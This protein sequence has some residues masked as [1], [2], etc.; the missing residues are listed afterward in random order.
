MILS[1]MAAGKYSDKLTSG[2]K[3][4]VNT[5]PRYI[6]RDTSLFIQCR[7]CGGFGYVQADGYP[8]LKPCSNCNGT[9]SKQIR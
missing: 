1:Y 7:V 9:G 5:A 8:E 2:E 4:D 6:P 3:P